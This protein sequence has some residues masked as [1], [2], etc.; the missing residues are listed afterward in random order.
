MG[1]RRAI[2]T[3]PF[4]VLKRALHMPEDTKILA[5]ESG[6]RDRLNRVFQ[7]YVEHPDLAEIEHFSALPTVNPRITRELDGSVKWEW[8]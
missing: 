3:V 5:V 6:I 8:E 1:Y 4:P 7:V 2:I